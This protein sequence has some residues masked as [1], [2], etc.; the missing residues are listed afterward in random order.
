MTKESGDRYVDL[1]LL[2]PLAQRV[3]PTVAE[4]DTPLD[5]IPPDS[6]SLAFAGDSVSSI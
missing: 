4:V 5:V 6:R 3:G 1:D 2:T